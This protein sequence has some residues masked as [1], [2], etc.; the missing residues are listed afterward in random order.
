MI[1]LTG[2]TEQETVGAALN[3]A[4]VASACLVRDNHGTDENLSSAM[5]TA[6][7]LSGTLAELRERTDQVVILGDNPEK[8]MPRFWEFVGSKKKEKA[9]R[10]GSG[11][12]LESIRQLRLM[13]RGMDSKVDANFKLDAARIGKAG[14]G[15]VFLNDKTIYEDVNLLTEMLLW[16]K[17]LGDGKKW[18]GQV[19]FPTPNENGI[20]QLLMSVTGHPGALSFKKGSAIHDPR[21]LQLEKILFNDEADVILMIGGIHRLSKPI[22]KKM[23]GIK[24]IILSVEKPD[25]PADAWLSCAQ[26]GIDGAGTMLRLDGIPVKFA[27]AGKQ[28]QTTGEEYL[29]RLAR[30]VKA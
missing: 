4:Q 29:I 19:L 25:I 16:L 1:V 21:T 8:T 23:D 3:L 28:E 12:S 26:V 5:R 20:S 10:L 24:T 30:E 14:S 13:N 27:P 18:Y 22:L 15:V 9:V 17:E 2:E 7:L 6:G 11:R